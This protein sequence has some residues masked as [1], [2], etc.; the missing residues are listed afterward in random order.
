M[1]KIALTPNASGSGTFTIAAPNSNTDRTLTLPDEA[2]TV[3]TSAS[4]IQQ[5]SGPTFSAYQNSS[6]TLATSTYTKIQ[7]QVEEWDTDSCYDNATNYRFTPTVEGYYQISASVAMASSNCPVIMQV[8]KNGSS[9]KVIH[10]T[11]P[12]NISNATGSG[13]VYLNGS[14]DYVEIY[15]WF[16]TG[17]GTAAAQKDTYFQA[18]FVRGV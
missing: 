9:Y 13:L 4:S 12:A 8:Y 15:A 7:F 18:V 3:L 1:S 6:Q 2:G 17:Q 11:N 10:N 5:N 14:T 16:G